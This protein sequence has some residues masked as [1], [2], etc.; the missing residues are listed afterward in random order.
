MQISKTLFMRLWL[1]TWATVLVAGLSEAQTAPPLR[2]EVASVRAAGL[3]VPYSGIAAAG[4]VRG[5]PGTSDPTRMT[6]TWVLVRKL[7]M[8][9]FA[10]PLDQISGSDWV[11]GQEARFD[12]SC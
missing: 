3:K 6:F 11:M 5:G 7:L 8:N 12:I 4:E 10:L 9:A 2:F 1:I